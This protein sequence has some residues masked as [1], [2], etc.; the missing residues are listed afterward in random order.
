MMRPAMRTLLREPLFHFLLG[1]AVLFALFG[2]VGPERTD[3]PDRV[4]VSE[5][6]V[7]NLVGAFER[8]WLRPPSEAE[9][10]GLIDDYVKEEILY[11]EA[12]ALGLDRD[13][14]VVRRRLRQKME[15][16]NED[17]VDLADPAE[18]DL[19]AYLEANADAYRVPPRTSFEQVFVDPE[20]SGD[21]ARQRAAGVLEAL[22]SGDAAGGSAG[23]PTLL[24]R[25]LE[26]AS[27]REMDDT[28]GPG[29]ANDVAALP[30]GEWAG[31]VA[32]A[33]GLHLVR[34]GAREAERLPGL[35]EVR[36]AVERD[37]RAQRR[38][39]ANQRFYEALRDRYQVEVQMPSETG[40]SPLASRDS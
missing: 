9:L 7:R 5:A 35:D 12:L 31:P 38:R 33:Y 1:G 10:E 39:E 24:P 13:D 17:L 18:A 25:R 16:L 15:F 14:L 34:V 11:R 23:D 6:R 30:E 21:D 27:P 3:A 2:Q 20:R 26:R 40:A 8:L 22:R 28:F 37:W 19:R 32:S 4:V 29:F 36:R